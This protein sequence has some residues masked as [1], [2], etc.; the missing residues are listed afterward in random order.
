MAKGV[1]SGIAAVI[2]APIAMTAESV[3]SGEQDLASKTMNGFVGFSKGK[4]DF[5]CFY[6][7]LTF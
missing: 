6:R 7:L 4:F 2:A 5:F 1:M 3:N